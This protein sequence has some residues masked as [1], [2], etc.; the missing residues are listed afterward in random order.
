MHKS[1]PAKGLVSAENSLLQLAAIRLAIQRRIM[2]LHVAGTQ[3][4]LWNIENTCN[5]LPS[6]HTKVNIEHGRHQEESCRKLVTNER[7]GHKIK[8]YKDDIDG[9]FQNLQFYVFFL[10]LQDFISVPRLLLPHSTPHFSKNFLLPTSHPL[11]LLNVFFLHT[12]FF[13]L[14]LLLHHWFT[15]LFKV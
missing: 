4:C 6:Q 13:P 7:P 3:T 2:G 11:P 5:S 15:C 8:I 10:Y 1:I 9:I 12:F 14:P